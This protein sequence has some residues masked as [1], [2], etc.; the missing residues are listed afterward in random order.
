MPDHT[1]P[2]DPT[3]C[4]L[5]ERILPETYRRHWK[6][7]PKAGAWHLIA[8]GP[9]LMARLAR[10]AHFVTILSYRPG[11]EDSPANYRGP[12]YGDGDAA[13]PAQAFADLRRCIQLLDTEY[14]C[15]PEAVRVWHSGNRGPHWM[16][17]A[18]VF[19]AEA[20]HL[21]LPRIYAAMI[22]RLFPPS[23]APTLDRA[24]YSKGKGR[25][26]R[27]PNRRRSDNG[28]YKV[29]L[30]VRELLHEPYEAL[31]RL[32]HRP[33]TGN[34][35]P[36]EPELSPCLGLVQLY[37]EVAA[38]VERTIARAHP[39]DRPTR[40]LSGKEGLLFHAFEHRGWLGH[41]I[42]PSKWAVRCPWEASH[43]SGA[44]FDTSTVLF[45]PRDGAVLGWFF[46]AHAHC[47]GRD[48]HDVLSLFTPGELDQARAT[49]G[50]A[51]N[52][53]HRTQTK[54]L[55]H[56]DGYA[57]PT[58]LRDLYHPTRSRLIRHKAGEWRYV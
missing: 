19:G 41:A 10:Q 28:R 51:V 33:R 36:S 3:S 13:D 2:H 15:P 5:C 21:L 26:L 24:V 45:A 42:D 30:S 37:R 56:P 12:L 44:P 29:P 18:L 54:G 50:I 7:G 8:D 47:A 58:R 49:A 43:S 52:D 16:I 22:E 25:M 6:H 35:W 32:T 1:L 46:C 17:P 38:T 55:L 14:G 34:F 20:G 40:H 57:A 27:L 53:R 23:V 39:L 9:D 31:E 48:L 11:P 4:R